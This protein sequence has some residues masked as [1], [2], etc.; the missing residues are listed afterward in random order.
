MKAAKVMFNR[1]GHAATEPTELDAV[2]A[3]AYITRQSLASLN[4]QAY[5]ASPERKRLNDSI[6]RQITANEADRKSA[7]WYLIQNGNG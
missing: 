6:D 5:R 3:L 4:A 1:A 2:L 7:L